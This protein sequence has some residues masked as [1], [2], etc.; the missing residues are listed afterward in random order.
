MS[1]QARREISEL[2]RDHRPCTDLDIIV[3]SEE[4]ATFHFESSDS[5]V[6]YYDLASITKLYTFS[7]AIKALL[8]NKIRLHDR[9][10][11]YLNLANLRE[12]KIIDII[13]HE[14]FIDVRLSNYRELYKDKMSLEAALLNIPASHYQGGKSFLYE[15][16]NYIYLGWILEEVYG[17]SIK[18]LF[19]NFFLDHGLRE[20][21]LPP[22]DPSV[23]SPTELVD[24]AVVRG[25]VH[26]ETAQILEG[27]CGHAGIFATNADLNKFGRLWLDG[28]C[29]DEDILRMMRGISGPSGSKRCFG[30]W[31]G[32]P[33]DPDIAGF[34]HHTGFTGC[35]LAINYEDKK[36]YS[37]TCNRT[38]LGRTNQ[39]H[40]LIWEYVLNNL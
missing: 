4:G 26:D 13:S 22:V 29:F 2:L 15:N 40:R 18:E 28:Q 38:Y 23:C 7:I 27:Y 10:I 31:R 11:D 6:S 3:S 30:W 25:V 24:G 33:H 5:S 14:A 39:N 9:C 19:M 16:I 34:Y 12:V 20:T 35:M 36:T 37:I 32:L 17:S 8:D 21:R 1:E